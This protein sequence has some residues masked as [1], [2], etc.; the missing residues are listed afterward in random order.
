MNCQFLSRSVE[1]NNLFSVCI[2]LN[3]KILP[4]FPNIPSKSQWGECTWDLK[5]IVIG[6][7]QYLLVNPLTQIFVTLTLEDICNASGNFQRIILDFINIHFLRVS[8]MDWISSHRS[9]IKSY[10][11]FH[12]VPICE[13]QFSLNLLNSTL[14]GS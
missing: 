12:H 1:R 14:F 9:N 7:T 10:N 13:M 8:L 11:T 6:V 3:L 2:I 5:L 4:Y